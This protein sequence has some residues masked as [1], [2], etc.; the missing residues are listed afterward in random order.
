ML[1]SD[2]DDKV[3]TTIKSSQITCNSVFDQNVAEAAL[4]AK[5]AT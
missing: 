4:T 2:F 3:K 5:T 1:Y